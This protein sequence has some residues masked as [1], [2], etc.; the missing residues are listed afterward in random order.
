MLL[1]GLLGRTVELPID[2]A[3]MERELRRLAAGERPA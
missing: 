1:S 3:L 2:A